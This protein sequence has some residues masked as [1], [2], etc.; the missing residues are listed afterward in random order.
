MGGGAES[1]LH[2]DWNTSIEA[3]LTSIHLPSFVWIMEIS[4]QE[5]Y[6]HKKCMGDIVIDTTATLSEDLLIYA[7][8][9]A[10]ILLNGKNYP[11]ESEPFLQF[12]NN[13]GK[14]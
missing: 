9:Q 12:I 3:L 10:S 8:T 11:Q 7:R 5:L 14:K 4:T 13:L 1:A 6:R 2:V